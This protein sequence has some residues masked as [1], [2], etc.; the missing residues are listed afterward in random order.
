MAPSLVTWNRVLAVV[1]GCI[2]ISLIIYFQIM[3]KRR[4][5]DRLLPVPVYYHE[6][7]GKANLFWE[8]SE[9]TLATLCV[10]FFAV[11]AFAHGFYAIRSTKYLSYVNDVG[12]LPYRW[13]EYGISA[14]IMVVILAMV[15]S[16][17]D[18]HA[19]TLLIVA[20]VAMIATGAWFERS[21]LDGHRRDAFA[22]IGVGFAL[23]LTIVTVI[24]TAF[25]TRVSVL[26]KEAAID[27]T[28]PAAPPKWI[29][30]AV[31]GT[32]IN[33]GCFG[34]VPVLQFVMRT[35]KPFSF[36]ERIYMGL[37]AGAKIFLGVFVAYGIGARVNAE[38]KR[39]AA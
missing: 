37:S 24:A 18:A 23:L 13:I 34:A 39:V 15:S 3:L 33:F 1:H 19:L 4:T 26:R 27:E 35:K 5:Q 2:A 12:W 8:G 28:K 36:Y 30:A 14:T 31:I 25:H 32:L 11:T 7:D 17:R 29:Y 38:V 20:N 21:L 9:E 10:A 22:A 6:Q 16:V